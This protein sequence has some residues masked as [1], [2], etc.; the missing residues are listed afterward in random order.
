MP[1]Y[2]VVGAGAGGCVIAARLSK[3][4]TVLLIEAGIFWQFIWFFCSSNI[5]YDIFTG[6]KKPA[7]VE[8][9]SFST[10]YVNSDLD[11]KQYINGSA[12][13]AGK[14]IGGSTVCIYFYC[15]LYMCFSFAKKFL[16]SFAFLMKNWSLLLGV[17]D[18]KTPSNLLR[19]YIPLKIFHVIHVFFK[20]S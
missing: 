16:F 5:L 18:K 2:I 12:G 8:P 17:N 14:G 13:G 4:Y 19:L 7:G 20:L 9:P 15:M 11:W 3:N 10:N 1:D 6:G